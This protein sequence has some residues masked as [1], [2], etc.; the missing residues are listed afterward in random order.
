VLNSAAREASIARAEG[1]REPGLARV[2]AVLIHWR[3]VCALIKS[4]LEARGTLAPPV[5]SFKIAQALHPL[6]DFAEQSGWE[7][8]RQVVLTAFQKMA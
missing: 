5:S 3:H 8:R 6:P 7:T 2:L 4:A 1:Y